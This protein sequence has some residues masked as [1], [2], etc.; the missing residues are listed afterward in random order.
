[1]SQRAAINLQRSVISCQLSALVAIATL[2][3]ATTA[4]AAPNVTNTTQKGSALM[5]P[6]V[7]IDIDAATPWNT[8]IRLQNDGADDIDVKC[9]WMDGNKN[10]VDFVIPITRNQAVWFDART[11]RGSIQVNVFPQA[12]ANGFD[13]PHL[14]TP[15]AA[16]EA[17]DGIGPYFK[18]ELTCFAV[19]A[20][21]VKQIKW[22]HLSGTATLYH[23]A[24][25]AYEYAAYAFFASAG[26]DR[27]PVGPA[28]LLK[29]DGFFYDACPLYQ[30]GQFT[31][32]VP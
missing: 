4:Q 7:R 31:P 19:D 18:G 28:G 1:M 26:V 12:A 15:P 2:V 6:D 13:N 14:I 3:L 11:G 16:N 22:N 21:G 8:L 24:K 23:A 5:F 20:A 17:A 30:I 9:Y 27:Q 25:G 32:R 29:L 10:R